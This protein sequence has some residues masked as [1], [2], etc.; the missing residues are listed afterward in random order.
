MIYIL[1]ISLS[2]TLLKLIYFQLQYIQNLPNPLSIPM[3]YVLHNLP[4][5]T[6]Y[7]TCCY[8]ELAYEALVLTSVNFHSNFPSP[9]PFFPCS[10]H[11]ASYSNFMWHHLY[12][13][14]THIYSLLIEKYLCE[15]Q[16][17]QL[18]FY[19]LFLV[20]FIQRPLHF[21]IKIGIIG[22]F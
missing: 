18:S 3:E 10:F 1:V 12:S 9:L 22:D 17:Y 16:Q 13:V 6:N 19:M 4:P 2:Q 20:P 7:I 5:N 8:L 14:F 21:F 15:C 11:G